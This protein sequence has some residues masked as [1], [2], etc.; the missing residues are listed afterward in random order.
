MFLGERIDLSLE[1]QVLDSRIFECGVQ[2]GFLLFELGDLAPG[3]V[4]VY[5]LLGNPLLS[6]V[7]SGAEFVDLAKENRNVPVLVVLGLCDAVVSR[8]RK[9]R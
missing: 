8:I 1:L 6:V 2:L 4:E 7:E 3:V 9:V 5:L